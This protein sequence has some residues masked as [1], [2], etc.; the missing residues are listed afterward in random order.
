MLNEFF[1]FLDMSKTVYH[2]TSN[3]ER[4]LLENNFVKLS[5][6]EE[7]KLKGGGKY[8]ISKAD[9]SIVAF[10]M[11]KVINNISK[12]NIISSHTD[13]P[14][15]KIKPETLFNMKEGKIYTETYGSPIISSWLDKPLSLGGKIFYKNNGKIKSDIIDFEEPVGVIPNLAIHLN[16]EINKGFEYNK[17]EHLNPVISFDSDYG[18]IINLLEEKSGIKI[19]NILS[20]DLFLYD[21]Q[22]TITVGIEKD[23]FSANKIDNL[24]M[25]FASLFSICSIG[26]I[27]NSIAMSVWFDNEEIGSKTLQGADSVFLR[28]ILERIT[29]NLTFSKDK[30]YRVLSESFMISAD[31]VHAIH[32]NFREKHDKNYSPEI[33]KGITVKY[34]ANQRYS[35]TSETAAFF[36]NLCNE[37]KIPFQKIINRSDIPSGSTIGPLSSANTG[38]KT[39]DAGIP[40]LAMHSIR[41]L[42]G[43]KDMEY[44]VKL[45][46]RF[47]ESV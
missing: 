23:L 12:F 39:V 18:N 34:N 46:D 2:A 17:Q 36:I 32:P 25:C 15:L 30:F 29:F 1:S 28:D 42:A 11:P 19:E 38:I 24:A 43:I 26:N 21:I 3:I 22:K 9:T 5:E 37:A 6:S 14:C 47:F 20:A 7:W 41:E 13:S 31:G 16:R 27:E 45:F 8:F 4:I 35:T 33:N 40:M 10:V 44:T